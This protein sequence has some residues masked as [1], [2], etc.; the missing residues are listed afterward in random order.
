MIDIADTG[1]GKTHRDENFPVASVLIAPQYRA[2]IMAFYNFVRAADDIADHATLK[3]QEKLDL[4]ERLDNALM[5]R[6]V[7]EPVAARLREECKARKLDPQHA[8]D[9]ITAFMRDVTYLRYRDWDD[10]IDYCRFSAM[11]VGRFVCDAH[12]E[13]PARVWEA[14]DALC[15]ALQVINHL[16]DCGKDYRDL[17]RVYITAESLSA[18]GGAVEMLGE[19]RAP[20]P[21]LAAIRDLNQ[22]T[23]GLL[24]QSRLF[25]DLI[26]DTRLAMEVGAIQALAE[27]LVARLAIADPLCEKVH[28]GK[29]G[30]A[31]AGA[32]GAIG[33][34]LRRVARLRRNI[35]DAKQ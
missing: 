24:D 19:P 32:Q 21:L 8:R 26:D 12:G 22:K 33:A 35:A 2:P 23:A 7:D 29:L 27:K 25:A 17:D 18:H 16:Q 4:L 3:P 28:A 5:E 15:A 31:L 1:S 10:L 34:L 30:F 13:D 20:A 9:L 14:N 6:G 11:P